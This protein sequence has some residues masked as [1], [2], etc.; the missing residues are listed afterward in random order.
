MD[1]ITNSADNIGSVKIS[2][3][4]VATIAGLA[5]AEVKG[6]SSMSGT[7]AGG[8]AEILGKKNTG[9]GVKV[10]MREDDVDI[11]LYIIAEYGASIPEIAWEIQE[12][13]KKAIEGMT[14]LKVEK[15]NVNIEGVHIEKEPKKEIKPEKTEAE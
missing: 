8:I 14:G 4:V 3:E 11:N 9:K 12:K 6:V 15:V 10:E 13:V 1:E 7:I 5:T 2:E